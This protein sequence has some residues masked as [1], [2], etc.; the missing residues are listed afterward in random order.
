VILTTIIRFRGSVRARSRAPALHAPPGET[1]PLCLALSRLMRS[2][3]ARFSAGLPSSFLGRARGFGRTAAGENSRASPECPIARHF[4]WLGPR[5][6]SPTTELAAELDATLNTAPP[7]MLIRSATTLSDRGTW[8]SFRDTGQV[9]VLIER[10]SVLGRL[11][12]SVLRSPANDTADRRKRVMQG[13]PDK[14]FALSLPE[15]P[16]SISLVPPS[17]SSA[18]LADYQWTNEQIKLLTDIRF[19]LLA[20]VPPAVGAAITLLS[21]T[22]LG[23][24][25]PSPL[26]MVAVGFL[27]FRITLGIVLYD[28]RN[29]QLY[30]ALVHRAA[31]IEESL[32]I[33][34]NVKDS[35]QHGGAHAL[36]SPR[37]GTLLYSRINHDG[38]LALVYGSVLA[39]WFYPMAKGAAVF[40]GRILK[41]NT[42]LSECMFLQESI[43]VPDSGNFT[44]LVALVITVPT[45]LLL[46]RVLSILDL[47]NVP[48]EG[49]YGRNNRPINIQQ[50]YGSV[51]NITQKAWPQNGVRHF[52]WRYL[53]GV[54]IGVFKYK[55]GNRVE[56]STSISKKKARDERLAEKKLIPNN[57]PGEA[58]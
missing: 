35:H 7:S 48:K 6:T 34:S 18:K 57:W 17:T 29:S 44:T 58:I 28:L 20:F 12:T 37:F 25:A 53:L 46:P 21:S 4:Y 51:E 2:C 27:G 32:E 45:V 3:S 52:F 26:V 19:R 23:S 14:I 56:Y 9:V 31:L 39:A 40:I 16:L 10:L 22:L 15:G 55:D 49:I 50:F 11:A 24:A 30:N 54:R 1:R 38:A 47:N 43:F 33:A 8:L 13:S 41:V 5:T 42:S 36:R